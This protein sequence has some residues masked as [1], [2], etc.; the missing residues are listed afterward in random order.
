MLGNWGN[1]AAIVAVLILAALG[2]GFV[3]SLVAQTT[4]QAVQYS[5]IVLLASIF[6]SGLFLGLDLL[7]P[8]VQVVSWMLPATYATQMLQDVM[9]RGTFTR[10]DLLL[11]LGAIGVALFVLAWA[12]LSRTMARQ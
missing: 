12:L 8:A 4:T 1:F 11:A 6:F 9:L 10:P 2:L 5:M 7:R 3:I